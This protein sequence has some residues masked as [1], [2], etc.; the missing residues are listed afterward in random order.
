MNRILNQWRSDK[1]KTALDISWLLTVFFCFFGSSILVVKL[2]HLPALYPFRV[3]VPLTTVL[4]MA[5][6]IREKRNPWKAGTFLQRVSYVLCAILMVYSTLS[7]FWA[8][9]ISFSAPIWIT[10]CFDLV[11][12]AL[13]LELCSDRQVFSDTVKCSVAALL[14]LFVMGIREVFWGGIFSPRYNHIFTWFGQ[15]YTSPAVTTG[16]PNDYAMMLV[17]TLA[18]ILLYWAWAGYAE[19]HNWI[20]VALAVSVYFLIYTTLGRLC[21]FSFWI[22]M[23]AFVLRLLASKKQVRRLLIPLAV[24]MG[25]VIGLTTYGNL[26]TKKLSLSMPDSQ[27][28][29]ETEPSLKD[30]IFVVDEQTGETQLNLALSGGIRV[31]LL[32]R[33]GECFV[34]SRGMGVGIGNTAQYAKLDADS[35]GGIWGIHCFLARMSADFGVWFLIPLLVIAFKM[36]QEGLAHTLQEMKKRNWQGVTTGAVY[37]AAVLIYP[38]ASTASGDAQNSLPMWLFMG[39]IV[40]FPAFMRETKETLGGK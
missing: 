1:L 23:A 36:V 26:Y 31:Q 16:N 40:L 28:V 12:F 13:S 19:K 37:L 9:D 39:I 3:L 14:I 11:F 5:W 8:I 17:F 2:P 38:I 35:R 18:L 33:A 25:I 20:P 4:Y 32:I 34:R 27:L 10:L 24:L 7:L 15:H 22:L 29:V 6:A 30:E 21:M